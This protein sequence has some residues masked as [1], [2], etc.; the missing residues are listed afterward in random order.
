MKISKIVIIV[1]LLFGFGNFVFAQSLV[2]DSDFDIK[3]PKPEIHI[4]K[5]GRVFIEGA[6]V[7]QF[8]G[9]TM[10]ARVIWD[11]IF[12][13]IVIKTDQNTSFIRR[14]GE[15]VN[16]SN[17]AVGNYLSI[18]GSLESNADSLS[19]MAAKIKNLSDL[20]QQNNFSGTILAIDPTYKS[21]SLNSKT[22]GTIQVVLDE[23]IS[24]V[25]GSRM[26]GK[27]YLKVGDKI[28]SVNGIYDHGT[29]I[30]KADKIIVYI[31]MSIFKAKNYSGILR[32][33]SSKT[34]PANL[35]ITVNSKDYTVKLSEK[36]EIINNKR[37]AIS[38]SRFIEG[39]R[40]IF[41]GALQETDELIIDDVE[42]IRN[43]SL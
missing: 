13:R 29:K 26:V 41:Y 11:N 28:I 42:I 22:L 5:D 43:A 15:A 24:I 32:S 36:T 16:I 27:S 25:L 31:N 37:K 12:L 8:T 10:Y 35:V 4:N 6:K 1:S 38:L 17:I 9:N 23:S 34:L 3:S 30:L 39:D 21:F 14:Y 19:I 40:V 20:T 18:E 33:I 2:S 7:M